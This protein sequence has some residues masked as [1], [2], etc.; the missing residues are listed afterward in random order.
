MLY[1][2]C[3][4]C[5]KRYSGKYCNCKT[6]REKR[7]GTKEQ[8]AERQKKYDVFHR[9]KEASAFY[10]SDDWKRVRSAVWARALGLDEYIYYTTGEAVTANTVHHIEPRKESPERAYDESNLI[11]VSNK[12]HKLLHELYNTKKKEETQAELFKAVGCLKLNE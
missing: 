11:S 1:R 5:G 8:I 4:H 6:S 3:N 2:I 12:T 7:F 9:D 10:H